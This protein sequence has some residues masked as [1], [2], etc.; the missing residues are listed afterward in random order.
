MRLMNSPD[1]YGAV[2]VALHWTMVVLVLAGWL[3]GEFGDVFPKGA[4]RETALAAHMMLGLA[5]ILTLVARFLWR[6]AD[7]LPLPV[8]TPFGSLLER[9]A[10]AVHWLLYILLGLV[11]IA[12]IVLQ[13]A[14]GGA[15]PVFGIFDI[16]SPWSADRQFAATVK[17]THELLANLLVIVAVLHGAAAMFHHWVLRDRTLK[18][19]LPDL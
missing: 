5:I 9:L 1:R 12:G 4:P 13:F 19:M 7:R 18:R 15:L 14:G 6:E 2:A 17:E 10:T 16:A 3:L 8:A 11:P